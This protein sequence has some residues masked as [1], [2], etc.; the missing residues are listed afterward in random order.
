[1][2]QGKKEQ[3]PDIAERAK[4]GVIDARNTEQPCARPF[5]VEYLLMPPGLEIN[6]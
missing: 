4:E 3:A 2:L 6:P 5:P 1:M